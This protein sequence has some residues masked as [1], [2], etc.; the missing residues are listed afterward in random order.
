MKEVAVQFGEQNSLTG[1]LTLPDKESNF[2]VVVITTVG[3]TTRFGPARVHTQLARSLAEKGIACLRYDLDSLGDSGSCYAHIP[4]KDRTLVEVG[5]ALDFLQ[6]TYGKQEF[7]LAGICSGAEAS[8]R[9]SAIDERVVGTIMVDPFSIQTPDALKRYFFFRL[10]RKALLMLNKF[11]YYQ[12]D[13]S[14]EPEVDLVNYT[15]MQHADVEPIFKQLLERNIYI[16]MVYTS[17]VRENVN[18]PGQLQKAF[19]NLPIRNRVIVDW[20]PTVTHS[21]I[22]V[23]QVETMVQTISNRLEKHLRGVR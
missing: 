23:E 12:P 13:P 6:N 7:I 19:P 8:F 5:H 4:L 1:V 21:P 10:K 22:F 2:P 15:Y 20:L 11:A 16:H 17:T 9:R 3:F 14:G 18:H